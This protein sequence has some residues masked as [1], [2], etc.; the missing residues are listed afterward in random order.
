[1]KSVYPI[2]VRGCCARPHRCSLRG[3]E[4]PQAGALPIA[5]HLLKLDGLLRSDVRITRTG[6]GGCSFARAERSS[7]C[8]QQLE[9]LGYQVLGRL[10][11]EHLTA[12]VPAEALEALAK[13][14][15]GARY[16][17]RRDRLPHGSCLAA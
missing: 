5:K 4:P 9:S 8:K 1:M 2:L 17:R 14:N 15:T 7:A 12:V 13:S 16:F 6:H 3:D 11:G 10:D